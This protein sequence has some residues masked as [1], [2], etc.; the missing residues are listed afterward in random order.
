MDSE[1]IKVNKDNKLK[2]YD[3]HSGFCIFLIMGLYLG[4]PHF[5]RN[6]SHF[7]WT[8]LLI[9]TFRVNIYLFPN[10]ALLLRWRDLRVSAHFVSSLRTFF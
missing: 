5:C 7:G 8:H 4:L 3:C 6:A 10:I 2:K 1:H 9:F